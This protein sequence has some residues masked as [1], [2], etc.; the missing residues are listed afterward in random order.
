[1]VYINNNKGVKKMTNIEYTD[2]SI[3]CIR[4]FDNEYNARKWI[5]RFNKTAKRLNKIGYVKILNQ[6]KTIE[7]KIVGVKLT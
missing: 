7:Y 1:M 2:K 3:T 5:A 4:H 6:F